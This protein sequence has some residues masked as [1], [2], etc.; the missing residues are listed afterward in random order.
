VIVGRD[1]MR[2]AAHI[3][4]WGC[5]S[6]AEIYWDWDKPRAREGYYRYDGGLEAC[7]VR[8]KA[9]APHADLIWMET[10]SRQ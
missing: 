1:A 6:V 3:S 8:G 10:K 2:A 7:I 5:R 9:F 4:H